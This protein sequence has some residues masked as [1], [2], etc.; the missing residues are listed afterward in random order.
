MSKKNR[1]K[2]KDKKG[3]KRRAIKNKQKKWIGSL[4][5]NGGSSQA[6]HSRSFV[7]AIIIHWVGMNDKSL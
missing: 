7:S 3:E 6:T 2:N 5:L 4:C 1:D